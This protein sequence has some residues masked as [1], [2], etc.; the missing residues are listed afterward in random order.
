MDELKMTKADRDARLSVPVDQ[1]G[2]TGHAR[3]ALGRLSAKTLG[4]ILQLDP[5]SV[6]DA[7]GISTNTMD[8]LRSRFRDADVVWGAAMGAP[9]PVEP[10][11]SLPARTPS[12]PALVAVLDL[13]PVALA[14]VK[15][16][17]ELAMQEV[18]GVPKGLLRPEFVRLLQQNLERHFPLLPLSAAMR[19]MQPNG[20]GAYHQVPDHQIQQ[21][22]RRMM[23]LSVIAL[24]ATDMALDDSDE[25]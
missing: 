4:D 14:V 3:K 19:L 22:K 21:Y 6:E 7:K 8:V 25:G 5:Q 9:K 13:R 12:K 10:A 2:L 11:A 23:I 24:A 20:Q 18:F 16:E 17:L 15:C 1:M